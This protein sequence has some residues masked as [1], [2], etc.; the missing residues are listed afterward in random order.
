M[1]SSVEHKYAKERDICDGKLAVE[2]GE[3]AGGGGR[4]TLFSDGLF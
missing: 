2:E 3:E 4:D 1:C